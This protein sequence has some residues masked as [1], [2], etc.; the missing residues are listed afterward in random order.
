[1]T[2]LMGVTGA[3]FRRLWNRDDGGNV[4]LMYLAP[5]PHQR[6]AQALNY[7]LWPVPRDRD[8]MVQAIKDN[9]AKGRP[10]IEFGIIG[11]PE[12]ALVTGYDQGGDAVIGWSYFQNDPH[13]GADVTFEPS[14]YYRRADWFS[15]MDRG[16]PNALIV[17]GDKNRWP[18]PSQREVLVSTL[19]WAIDLERTSRRPSLPDH[20]SGLAAYEAW[21]RGLEVDADYPKGDPQVMGTRAMIHGDQCVMLE[22]RHSAARFLR[23]MAEVAPEAAEPMQAA[24]DLYDQAADEGKHVWPWGPDMAAAQPG[25]PTRPSGAN[26]PATSAW[27]ATSRRK[28]S[29]RWRRRWRRSRSCN[30]KLKWTNW[31]PSSAIS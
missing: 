11:P 17:V 13:F 3:A 27:P 16:G 18:G 7:E 22:E 14:G 19:K 8:R 9:I 24:A 5:E 21:A 31:S 4:D 2:T 15:K 6:A 20:V 1:M 26:W 12:A 29:N 10:L 25:W 30:N 23:K 28:P